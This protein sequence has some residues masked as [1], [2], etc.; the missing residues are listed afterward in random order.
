MKVR[1]RPELHARG[2][3]TLRDLLRKHTACNAVQLD[4]EGVGLAGVRWRPRR[5]SLR[6]RAEGLQLASSCELGD[7]GGEG[8]EAVGR[9][10]AKAAGAAAAA[11]GCEGCGESAG[12]P[13]RDC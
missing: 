2:V 3:A 13:L 1:G 5:L 6:W 12:R 11:C 7:V 4:M 9:R 8:E 10:A